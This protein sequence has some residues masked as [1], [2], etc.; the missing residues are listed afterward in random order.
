MDKIKQFSKKF[1]SRISYI[2]GDKGVLESRYNDLKNKHPN[3]VSGKISRIAQIGIID[4]SW[5]LFC[6]GKFGTKDLHTVLL[7][8]SLIDKWT[9]NK[10]NI[11]IGDKNSAFKKFFQKL[12][13]TNPKI[14]ATMQ[15]WMVYALMTLSVVAGGKIISHKDNIK[16]S[17][18]EWNQNRKAEAAKRGTFFEYKEFLQPITPWLIAQLIAAE[19]VHLENGLHTPYQDS[20]GIW[21]IGF[22]CTCLKDGTHVTQNTPPLTNEE[23]YD[24]ARWHLEENETYFILYCYSVADK[25]LTVR[26]TGEAFALSS[27]I[28]NSGTNLI[29]DKNDM[30]HKERFT[31]LRSLYNEYGDAISDSLVLDV[32]EKHPIQNKVSFGK[33]WMDSHDKQD[34]AKAIGGYMGDGAG[35]H[36]RRWLEAGL[37]TGDI[38]PQDLLNCPIEGMYDFYVYIGGKKQGKYALWE[39]TDSGLKPKKSTYAAFKEWLKRPLY[40]DVKNDVLTVINRKTVSEFLPD[41]VL[42]ECLTGCCEIGKKQKT[43]KQQETVEKKTYTIGYEDY[44]AAAIENYHQGNYEQAISILENLVASNPNNALLHND[45]ALMYNKIGEY[46][47]AIEHA[48][49]IVRQIGDK[50]QYG[51]A[52]YN[53]GVAY[54]KLGNLESALKNY[55]LAL[56]NGNTVASGAI[57]RVTKEMEKQK[58][59]VVAFNNAT[60]KLQNKKDLAKI[61]SKFSNNNKNMA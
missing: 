38:E 43:H 19:G 48:Q 16:D 3:D 61:L 27:I 14:S 56:L 6:L 57:E 25:S 29:E 8:N 15:L 20:N 7:N 41:Y 44:Y 31:L 51:A 1:S 40:L 36:W 30:D 55:K 9:E 2:R 24:L 49:K 35:M 34:M 52:Q 11:K 10:K 46:N 60:Q 59:K 53:A 28:Y 37:I 13:K 5:F 32:F 39:E 54:E 45:L 42:E 23:A 33:S 47:K 58:N 17:V 12:Q 4:L 26:N 22:G 50:S 18:K 21:T